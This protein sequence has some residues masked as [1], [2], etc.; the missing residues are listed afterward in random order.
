MYKCQVCG[1][2]SQKGE[3]LYKKVVETRAK[4]YLC[5]KLDK[6]TKKVKESWETKGWEIV[7]EV[8]CHRTCLEVG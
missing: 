2:F 5:E 3:R 6:E 4:V 8:N 1:E 7:R